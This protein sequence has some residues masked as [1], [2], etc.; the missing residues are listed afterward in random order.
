IPLKRPGPRSFAASPRPSSANPRPSSTASCPS[1]RTPR[2]F[3]AARPGA[4]PNAVAAPSLSSLLQRHS[5]NLLATALVQIHTGTRS[6]NTAALIDPCTPTSCV[7]A[8]LAAAFRL[9]TTNVGGEQ[10]CSATVGS[11]IDSAVRLGV[12]FKIE[13]HVRIRTPVRE[14]SD[15]V[16][17]HFRDIT[18]A[19]ERLY[20]PA[21][22][23]V[24]LGTDMCP[25][26]IKPGFRK[27][28]DGLPVARSTVFGWVVSEACHQP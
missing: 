1:P 17:A 26:V 10:I 12:V 6:F 24:V 11:K 16:R 23:S 3:S 21:S 5:V 14:L 19:D 4:Q 27:I 8:S 13:P 22:I 25:R 15:A 18:L 7:D 20:L 28:D 9:P 2:R